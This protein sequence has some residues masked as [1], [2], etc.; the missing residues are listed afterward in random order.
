MAPNTAIAGRAPRPASP[1]NIHL[2]IR[3]VPYCTDVIY[4]EMPLLPDIS[5]G[6]LLNVHLYAK[7][8]CLQS[9]MHLAHRHFPPRSS[10]VPK[11]E[12]DIFDVPEAS[13]P[14]RLVLYELRKPNDEDTC[15]SALTTVDLLIMERSDLLWAVFEIWLPENI[16]LCIS[17]VKFLGHTLHYSA[18]N[19]VSLN[20]Q[21]YWA[22]LNL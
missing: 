14:A 18:H 4:L 16:P 15:T 12:Q 17:A 1:L 6:N 13:G 11:W 2:Q 10:R 7:V 21:A 20:K 9:F 22:L 3:I 8:A 5:L 19:Y